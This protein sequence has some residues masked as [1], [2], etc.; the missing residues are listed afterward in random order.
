MSNS[1]FT[2][3]PNEFCLQF[4]QTA[5]ILNAEELDANVQIKNATEGSFDF[6]TLKEIG[7]LSSYGNPQIDFLAV[8]TE[9]QPC[10]QVHVRTINEYKDKLTFTLADE[11][12]VSINA[13]IWGERAHDQRFVTGLIIA[14]KGAKISTFGGKSINIGDNC[15][16]QFQPK[17]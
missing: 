9:L 15:E 5:L 10:R 7:I 6:L 8:I 2:I 3:I 13:T 14:V 4:D 1:K 17:G 11:T 16:I 12:N